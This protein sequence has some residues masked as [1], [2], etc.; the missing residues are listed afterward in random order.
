[1][2]SYENEFTSSA[3][4]FFLQLSFSRL[5]P[6]PWQARDLMPPKAQTLPEKTR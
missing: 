4:R 3:T 6:S 5:K 1:M 2:P